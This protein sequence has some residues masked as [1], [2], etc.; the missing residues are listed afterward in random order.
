MSW[1]IDRFLTGQA[2]V[3]LRISG[4]IAAHD[5]DMLRDLL[6]QETGAVAL[7]FTHLRLVDRDAVKV[8]AAAEANG[9]ELRNCPAYVREWV[10]RE[11]AQMNA[12]SSDKGT[13]ARDDVD[14]V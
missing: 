8:L 9:V 14:D 10:A 13:P 12:T 1:R 4:R 5:V 11:R 3:V 6:E 7:D 2:G